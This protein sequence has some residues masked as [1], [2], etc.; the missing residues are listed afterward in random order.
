MAENCENNQVIS[1]SD[2][3]NQGPTKGSLQVNL[4]AESDAIFNPNSALS[5]LNTFLAMNYTANTMFGI[6]SNWFRA[7]PQDRSKDVIFQ[8]WTLYNVAECPLDIKVVLPDGNFPDSKYQYDLMGLEYEIPLEIHIDK[9]YWEEISGVGTAPQKKDIVYLTL[10]NKLYQIESSYLKRGFMEQETTWVCNLIKYQP[11][12]SRR[13][14]AALQDTIDQYT[15]SSEEIFGEAM[16][17]EYDKLSDDKQ[18]SPLNSTEVDKYKELDESLKI[19][20]GDLEFYGLLVSESVY[21]MNTSELFNAVKYKNSGD[22]IELTSDRAI[23]EWI[24]HQP[25]SSTPEFDIIWIM[26]DTTL[27]VPANYKIKIR[28]TTIFEADDNLVISRPGALNLYAVVVDAQFASN[29]I[30]YVK[31]DDEVITHL[32]SI[33]SNWADARNYKVTHRDPI[34]IL[35]GINATDT[36]FQVLLY[37]NQYIK[38]NYGIQTY[39]STI[40]ER[41]EDF[42]WYGIVV[43]IGNSWGQYNVYVWEASGD[44]ETKLRIKYY[45]T[46]KFNPEHAIVEQYTVDKSESYITNIRLYTTTIEEEKQAN[47]LLSYFSKDADQALIL[48]NC[49]QHFLAP[50]VSQQR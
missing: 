18:F 46:I 22:E 32:N 41:L 33:K 4:S 2:T 21:D 24:N 25:L 17:A 38:I 23:T 43:N 36:G 34:T 40:T 8:E 14:S 3:T 11:E 12:A 48:D 9:R 26:A 31:I 15:V 13:E 42:T 30:Y 39:V 35:D 49:D 19:L 47:E 37:A 16:N 6:E 50:Y 28:T 10:P 20:S 27:T 45:E 1:G 5:A 44:S 7:V 29:G